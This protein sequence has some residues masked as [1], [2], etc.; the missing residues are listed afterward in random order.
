MLRAA[1][2]ADLA[3]PG[4]DRRFFSTT[5]FLEPGVGRTVLASVALQGPFAGLAAAL[6]PSAL[7][8]W[9]S[10]GSVLCHLRVGDPGQLARLVASLGDGVAIRFPE[11]AR[12]P[13]GSPGIPRG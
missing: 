6:F 1:A 10:A 2:R 12:A 7:L 8:E 9:S 4:F 5:G 3:P 11:L 13:P